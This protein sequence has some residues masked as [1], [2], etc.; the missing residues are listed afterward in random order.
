MAN[1]VNDIVLV[2]LEDSPLFFARIESILPDAKKD[3]YH[4]KLLMLQLPL[5]V[6][7][8][9]LKD[10]Y[11]NGET[12]HMNGKKMRLEKVECPVEDLSSS[13]DNPLDPSDDSE[14]NQ[15]SKEQDEQDAK[16]ISFSDLKKD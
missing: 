7:T 11:I 8:W 2:Y 1:T 9:I 5:Q 3:W 10:D 12:Y 15:P 4:I 16:I 13:V 6:V 14:T